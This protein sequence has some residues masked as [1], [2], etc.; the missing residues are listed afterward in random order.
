MRAFAQLQLHQEHKDELNALGGRN[1]GIAVIRSFTTTA[2]GKPADLPLTPCTLKL[3]PAS[4]RSHG[5]IAPS[6]PPPA[7]T[8]TAGVRGQGRITPL[9]CITIVYR[10]LYT[11][12]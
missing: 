10:A 7:T 8:D 12:H 6:Q 11:E 9:I 3:A 1:L 4:I 2:T 5:D